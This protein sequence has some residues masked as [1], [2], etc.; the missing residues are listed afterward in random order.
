MF[1]TVAHF[2]LGPQSSQQEGVLIDPKNT[3][4]HCLRRV[5][6]IPGSSKLVKGTSRLNTPSQIPARSEKIVFEEICPFLTRL[7]GKQA[8][9]VDA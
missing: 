3:P 7:R 6:A 8:C 2:T 1:F 5:I 4:S 9:N